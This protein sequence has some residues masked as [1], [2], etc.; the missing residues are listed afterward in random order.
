MPFAFLQGLNKLEQ[1]P[2][3]AS[4]ARLGTSV[5]C[6]PPRD[7]ETWAQPTPAQSESRGRS[8]GVFRGFSDDASGSNGQA[9]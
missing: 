3:S 8:V 9:R 5:T 7:P 4:E 1:P 2:A 6:R